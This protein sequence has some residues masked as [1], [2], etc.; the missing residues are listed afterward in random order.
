[1]FYVQLYY[2]FS[3]DFVLQFVPQCKY[4]TQIVL[5][6]YYVSVNCLSPGVIQNEFTEKTMSNKV[7][8][9]AKQLLIIPRFG[10]I[11]DLKGAAVFLASKESDYM[12]GQTISINGGAWVR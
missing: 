12:T 2:K 5:F 11:E 4:L 9:T 1:M 6:A 8:K 3:S 7:K 10:K